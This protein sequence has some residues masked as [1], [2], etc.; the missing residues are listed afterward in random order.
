MPNETA[1]FAEEPNAVPGFTSR[2][3]AAAPVRACRRVIVAI[4]DYNT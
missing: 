4:A 3:F 2:R 1:E